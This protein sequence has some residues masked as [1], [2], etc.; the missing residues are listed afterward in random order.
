[1]YC[2]VSRLNQLKEEIENVESELL[3]TRYNATSYEDLRKARELE[4]RLEE[5]KKE[6]LNALDHL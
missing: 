1:M 4:E 5:L 2:A 3:I 6:Y